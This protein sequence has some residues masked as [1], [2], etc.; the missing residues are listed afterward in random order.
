MK[1]RN[2]AEQIK[3]LKKGEPGDKMTNTFKAD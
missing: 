1:T 2:L 3:R